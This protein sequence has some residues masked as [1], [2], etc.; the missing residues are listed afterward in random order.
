MNMESKIVETLFADSKVNVE[1]LKTKAYNG[2][3]AEVEEG[4]IPLT[5]AD[6]DFPVAKEITQSIVDYL[7]DG[8]LSYTPH[9]GLESFKHS[10]ANYI[11]KYKN[12]GVDPSLVLPI[13]SAARGMYIIAES[14]LEVG[15]EVIVF[16][17]VDYLFRES[18]LAAG[19]SI[20]LFPAKVVD[21]SI[22]LSKLENY[23]TEKTKMIC[24][25]NPHNPLGVLYSKE[26][27]EHILALANKYDLWIMNDEIWSDIVYKESS[28]VSILSLGDER[29][30]KIL[31]VFGFSKS[32][33]VAGLRAGAIYAHDEEIFKTIIEKAQ[34]LTTAGGISSLS[35]IGATAALDKSRY[36]LEAFLEHLTSNRDYGYSRINKMK[37]LRCIRPQATY[38][39]FVDISKTGLSS[40]TFTQRLKDEA[41]LAVVPGV[42]RFFGPGAE[43]YVRI[44]F[45][46]SRAILEEALN[47]LESWVNTL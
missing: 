12:E 7:E 19:A 29:N 18:S 2:R 14:V 15:D 23:I 27:L 43:G 24:L 47:R 41:K 44:C 45:A 32:F 3:W 31:S 13:D 37:N 6:P 8:Y 26:D 40:T 42:S 5:A 39:F 22:D 17:P 30:K 28:F 16:D 25:C 46:T 11:N 38:M 9:T 20:T 21:N 10:I 33:G 4:V 36:W 1:A 34:V 35:Q